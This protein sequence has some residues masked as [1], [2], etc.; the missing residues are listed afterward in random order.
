MPLVYCPV[1]WVPAKWALLPSGGTSGGSSPFVT[2]SQ[3]SHRAQNPIPLGWVVVRCC[4]AFGGPGPG[5]RGAARGQEYQLCSLPT[6]QMMVSSH[7]RNSRITLLTGFSVRGS[8]GSSSEALM[9]T[10]LSEYEKGD[11][12]AVGRCEAGLSQPHCVPCCLGSLWR[13]GWGLQGEGCQGLVPTLPACPPPPWL[14]LC[15]SHCF[16]LGPQ[17]S[18]A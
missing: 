4:E 11:E 9:G 17:N 13:P 6:P 1:P 5:G 2:N 7:L 16:Q 15:P 12:G 3:A 18:Q 14:Q 8:C 10:P